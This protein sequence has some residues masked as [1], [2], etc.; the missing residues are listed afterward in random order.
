MKQKADLEASLHLLQCQKAATAAEAEAAAY[1][2]VESWEPSLI[3]DEP[4]NTVQR[5]NDYVHQHSQL[6]FSE[7]PS[8]HEA[9]QLLEKKTSKMVIS[10][11]RPDSPDTM[12]TTQS[13][14]KDV[15]GEPT[16]HAGSHETTPHPYPLHLSFPEK[17]FTP[18]PQ[19]AQDLARYLIRKEMVSSGLLK[20][21]DK[22]ENYWSWKASF[23]SATKDL[24][25]TAREELD[26]MTKWLGTESSEQAKRI[27]SVHVLNTGAGSNM[28]W[29]CLEE[30]YGTPEVIEDAL[31][32]KTEQFP[33]LHNRDTVKL[34]ELGDILL[35]LECAKE[36]GALP[37]LL[38]LDM[39]REIKKIVEKL[40]Y[41]LQEKWSEWPFLPSLFSPTS[42]D[43]KQKSKMTQVSSYLLPTLHLLLRLTNLK[44]TTTS[45]L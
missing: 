19:G 6:L 21:D 4:M 1:E 29:Q 25:L 32:K 9:R 41:N 20:F 18:E 30:C 10:G 33:K 17:R 35:E 34:R 3:G 2:E 38:Y 26:L 27:C 15:K 11:N 22:P 8:E 42:S 24:D 16:A 5:T 45:L 39:A 7:Q 43:N 40:P 28:V 36:D 31:L 12:N 44:D 14:Y 23:I 37:G 13:V